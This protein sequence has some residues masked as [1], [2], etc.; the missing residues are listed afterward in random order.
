ML[1][2]QHGRLVNLQSYGSLVTFLTLYL[3]IDHAVHTFW[4]TM[5]HAVFMIDGRLSMSIL[6]QCGTFQHARHSHKRLL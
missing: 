1:Y 6:Q 5:D 3:P 2:L 4:L